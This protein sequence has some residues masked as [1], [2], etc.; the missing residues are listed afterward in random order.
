MQEPSS[1]FATDGNKTADVPGV[2]STGVSFKVD[3]KTKIM[4][5]QPVHQRLVCALRKIL[6]D[7]SEK[8]DNGCRY[9]ILGDKIQ[10]LSEPTDAQGGEMMRAGGRFRLGVCHREGHMSRKVIEFKVTFRD[11]RNDMN[12]P[13]VEYV[14]PTTIQ[15]LPASTKLPF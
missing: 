1:L 10:I 11:T 13:D 15:A 6:A 4:R 8:A 3:P 2:I 9:F 14:D 12:L 5:K 7:M